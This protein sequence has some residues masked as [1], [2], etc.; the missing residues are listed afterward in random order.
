MNARSSEP[1]LSDNSVHPV[2]ASDCIEKEG[3]EYKNLT[4][5]E[6]ITSVD[7]EQCKQEC[8]KVNFV[9]MWREGDHKNKCNMYIT[10]LHAGRF[11]MRMVCI[12]IL[13]YQWDWGWGN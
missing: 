13:Q 8:L 11:K 7:K 1:I 2:S 9:S 12:Q 10:L 4:L 5:I 6:N 3:F